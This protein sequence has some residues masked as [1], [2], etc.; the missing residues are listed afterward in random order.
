MRLDYFCNVGTTTTSRMLGLSTTVVKWC[1]HANPVVERQRRQMPPSE[2]LTAHD[3]IAHNLNGCQ[4]TSRV[5]TSV[6]YFGPFSAG[7]RGDIYIFLLTDCF[8]LRAG[9][10]FSYRHRGN[11]NGTS[12]V[13]GSRCTPPRGCPRSILSKNDLDGCLNLR[14]VVCQHVGL[15]QTPPSAYHPHGNGM[16]T[17]AWSM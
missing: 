3:S 10:F 14:Q 5:S 4:M 6:N 17:V 7:P 8:S 16:A 1:E 12:N 13:L 9:P 15:R 2:T 11:T